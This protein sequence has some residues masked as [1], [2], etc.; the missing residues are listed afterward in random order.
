[1]AGSVQRV[2][3]AILVSLLLVPS[4]NT[5]AAR[6]SDISDVG[7]ANVAGFDEKNGETK[8]RVEKVPVA[9]EDENEKTKEPFNQNVV[10]V[11]PQA[12]DASI[13]IVSIRTAEIHSVVFGF[14]FRNKTI[15]Q[16]ITGNVIQ[17]QLG[18]YAVFHSG[19]QNISGR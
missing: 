17:D 6:P 15:I 12:V 3:A 4:T 8:D 14:C 5:L 13:Q 1:M 9:S 16:C 11:A 2:I 10:T 19:I 18:D 7:L